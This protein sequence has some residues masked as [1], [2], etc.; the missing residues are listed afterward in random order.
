MF[1]RNKLKERFGAGKS[2]SYLFLM[3]VKEKKKLPSNFPQNTE[4]S[5]S[6]CPS[7]DKCLLFHLSCMPSLS[8]VWLR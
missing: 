8:L 6:F 3:N 5:V 7:S 1:S 4:M 2:P